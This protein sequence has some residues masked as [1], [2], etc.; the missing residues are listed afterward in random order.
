MAC[1]PESVRPATRSPG[2]CDPQHRRESVLE[3]GLDGA[4]VGLTRP[5]G[6]IR[7]VIRDVEADPLLRIRLDIAHL[8]SA[9]SV[10]LGRLRGLLAAGLGVIAQR[11]LGRVR[12]V[13]GLA[14]GQAQCSQAALVGATLE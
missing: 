4:L 8:F 12:G 14:V 13:L 10:L 7:A 5:S 11:L 1:T 9:A 6:E 2:R 3:H